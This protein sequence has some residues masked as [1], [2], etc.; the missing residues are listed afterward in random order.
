MRVNFKIF[1]IGVTL[2]AALVPQVSFS[3]AFKDAPDKHGMFSGTVSGVFV[4]PDYA[5]RPLFQ[6]NSP[7]TYIAP[8]GKKFEAISEYIVD[9]ASI[10]RALWSAIGGPF[11][12]N[13][14]KPSVVHD[15]FTDTCQVFD[16][17]EAGRPCQN[18]LVEFAS[19]DV[20]HKNYYLGMLASG[21]S[22]TKAC[23][24]YL[25]VSTY[26]Q[27]DLDPNGRPIN[28][29]IMGRPIDAADAGW[30]TK[31]WAIAK[32]S[33]N[34][35]IKTRKTSQGEFLNIFPDGK[36]SATEEGVQSY[37]DHLTEALNTESYKTKLDSLGLLTDE[38]VTD[39]AS[40]PPWNDGFLQDRFD[41]VTQTYSNLSVF[42]PQFGATESILS[43]S[44]E[45]ETKPWEQQQI[46]INLEDWNPDQIDAF[47]AKRNV[48]KIIVGKDVDQATPYEIDA[49]RLNASGVNGGVSYEISPSLQGQLERENIEFP[50]GSSGNIIFMT[51]NDSAL[52]ALIQP[53]PSQ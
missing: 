46:Q 53:A 31:S 43:Q 28:I 10:P 1:P 8:N 18:Q 2:F 49:I 21:V 35:V 5:E 42:Q 41:P 37:I 11:S 15:Y 23:A 38:A 51:P 30:I 22:E 3:C 40:I 50:Y 17:P 19:A 27:W 9:G 34:A 33:I 44:L 6:L 7:I 32:A 29:L 52:D 36:I 14:L 16:H 20:V 24:E 45:L 39:I 12:G 48:W 13:H 25:A 26:K 4:T 47:D